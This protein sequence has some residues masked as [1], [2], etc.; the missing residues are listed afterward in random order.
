MGD[1]RIDDEGM[2]EMNLGERTRRAE[3]MDRVSRSLTNVT[4]N[5]DQINRIER[6][7]EVAKD[8]AACVVWNCPMSREQSLALT[9]LED[10]VMWAV[11]SIVLEEN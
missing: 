1:E 4:P 3:L 7:R 11:K 10:A 5:T 8:L 2:D 9:H 6:L